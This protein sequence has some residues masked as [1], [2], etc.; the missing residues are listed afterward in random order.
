VKSKGN[1]QCSAMGSSAFPDY[2]TNVPYSGRIQTWHVLV[3]DLGKSQ[4]FPNLFGPLTFTSALLSCNAYE[5]AK[6]LLSQ[7]HT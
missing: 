1:S 4:Y 7:K 2:W 3:S 5:H 6:G